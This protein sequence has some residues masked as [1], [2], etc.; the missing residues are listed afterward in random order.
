MTSLNAIIYKLNCWPLQYSPAAFSAGVA[1]AVT[2]LSF[3]AFLFSYRHSNFSL[4]KKLCRSFFASSWVFPLV[5]TLVIGA[6]WW[7]SLTITLIAWG[8][9]WLLVK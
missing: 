3:L 1:G 7:L 9:T 6:P 4:G 5:Y 2:F 8:G